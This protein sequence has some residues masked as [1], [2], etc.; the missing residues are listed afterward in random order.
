MDSHMHAAIVMQVPQPYGYWP[1]VDV[2]GRPD[3]TAGELSPPTEKEQKMLA[4]NLARTKLEMTGYQW[5]YSRFLPTAPP[6]GPLRWT[7]SE[8]LLPPN[9]QTIYLRFYL[10]FPRVLPIQTTTP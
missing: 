9:A 8:K 3:G 4:M 5:S 1:W 7:T 2:G 10:N 6:L